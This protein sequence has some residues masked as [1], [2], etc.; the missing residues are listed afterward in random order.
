M[1]AKATEKSASDLR[2]GLVET[3]LTKTKSVESVNANM[4][5]G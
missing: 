5:L 2:D 1:K 4:S 3:L